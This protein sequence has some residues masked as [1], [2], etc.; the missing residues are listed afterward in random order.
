MAS[1]ENINAYEEN[2]RLGN[3]KLA[4]IRNEEESSKA[5]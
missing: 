1:G 2:N 5:K 4:I 3:Q